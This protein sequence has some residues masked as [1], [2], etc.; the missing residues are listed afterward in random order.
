MIQSSEEIA[1]V[2]RESQREARKQARRRLLEAVLTGKQ[3]DMADF[4]AARGLVLR[5]RENS[6]FSDAWVPL[7]VLFLLIGLLANRNPALLALGAGLLVLVWVSTQWKNVALLGVSYQRSFDRTRV[8]PGEAIAMTVTVSNNKLLPLSWVQFRDELPIAPSTESR[9][10][11]TASD[12]SGR[13]VLQHSFSLHGWAHTRRLTELRF[14]SRGYYSV[15]PVTYESGDLFTLFTVERTHHDVDTLIVYPQIWPLEHLGLP[16][17]EPFGEVKV[18]RSLFTDPIRTQGIREYRPQDRFRDIHWKATARRG[19]LQ[20]RVF[21]PSTGMAI[22]VFLN[23]ATYPKHWMG[24][25]PELL[26]RSI[27]VAGSIASYGVEQ[28]WGVGFYANGSVPGSDQPIRVPPG[29][30]REQL[31]RILEALAAVREFATG[32][33]ELMMYRESPSLPWAATMVLVT[34]IV[35]DEMMVGLIRLREAGR[36][37]VLVSLSEDAPPQHLGDILAYHIPADV[38]AFQSAHGRRTATEAALGAIP[39]PRPVTLAPEQI[40]DNQGTRIP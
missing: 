13:Y 21:D 29:R 17:K 27:S 34:S 20:T 39:T 3:V 28:G 1:L 33:I 36:R 31:N 7:A 14:P 32:G 19:T 15:G 24:F 16:A 8:F 9:I 6:I 12:I 25:D 30:S 2:A 11:Q 35:T 18:R 5:E 23:V 10:A 4:A 38:P 40:D 37:V 22:A 26:E